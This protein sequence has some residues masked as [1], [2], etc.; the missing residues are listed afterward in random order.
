MAQLTTLARP[1]AKAAFEE[2]LAKNA[3]QG[4]SQ[5]LGTLGAVVRDEK[6]AAYLASPTLTPEGKAKALIELCAE[7]LDELGRNFVRVLAENKR[8]ALLPEIQSL[9]EEFKA[10]Q[11][12]SVDVDVVSAFDM[13][14]DSSRRLAESLRQRLQ[15]N[16][17]IT[18]RVDRSLI[19]GLIVR[20]GDVVIDGSV[21]GRIQKLAEALNS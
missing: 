2:A 4:W 1:Y 5:M 14:E 9:F 6:V 11:E 19:G 17:N 8:L 18:T 15:R 3:L 20:A 16:V 13:S 12:R 21:R 7:A 10:N